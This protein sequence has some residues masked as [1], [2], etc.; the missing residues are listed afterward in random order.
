MRRLHFVIER[1][2]NDE[3]LIRICVCVS[4]SVIVSRLTFSPRPM[5]SPEI[6][7][8]IIIVIVCGHDRD[9]ND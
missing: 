7:Q 3:K 4:V 5:H 8:I 1:M 9:I 2:K 6:D